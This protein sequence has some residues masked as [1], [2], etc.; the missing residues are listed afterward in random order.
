MTETPTQK[1]G[2]P[3][4]FIEVVRSL[5]D[6]RYMTSRKEIGLTEWLQGRITGALVVY[7]INTA[8]AE[9]GYK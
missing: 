3:R 4:I 7:T 9:L 1:L 8:L 5:S 6:G 2:E